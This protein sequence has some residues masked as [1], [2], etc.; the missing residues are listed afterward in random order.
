MSAAAPQIRVLFI[1]HTAQLGGGELALLRLLSSLDRSRIEP[2]V[3]LAEEGP[4]LVALREAGIAVQV[5]PLDAEIRDAKKDALGLAGLLGRAAAIPRLRAYSRRLAVVAKELRVDVVHCN[6]LKSDIY[7]GLAGRRASVPVVWHVRDRIDDAYLPVA[8]V[9]LLRVL[10]R[11]WSDAV[12]TDTQGVQDTL[13]LPPRHLAAVIPSGLSAGFIARVVGP[14][15]A[16][17]PPRIG[18]I[19]RLAPWKGQHVFIEAAARLIARGIEARFRIVGSALFGEHAYEAQLRV[20][21]GELG[22]AHYVEFAGFRDV[23]DE[24]AG[25]DLLVHASTSPEPFGQVIL[26]GMAAGIPVIATDAGGPREIITHDRTGLLVPMGD[27]Q[28]LAAA[29]EGL[30]RDPVRAGALATAGREHALA[31]YTVERSARLLEAFYMRLLGR[32]LPAL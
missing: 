15:V 6:S 14:R 9:W 29:I 21:A 18:L 16:H 11:R 17:V 28:A 5:L 31:N 26:E 4:L 2:V 1:D 25:L 19:G 23:A 30:L 3:V 27:A 13:R 24:L 22:L 12:V 20:R 8:A 32:P 7:G 10:L